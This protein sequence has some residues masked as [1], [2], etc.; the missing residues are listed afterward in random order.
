MFDRFRI[1]IQPGSGPHRNLDFAV[2]QRIE[3]FLVDDLERR[4]AGM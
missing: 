4:R 3:F 1:Q 2:D